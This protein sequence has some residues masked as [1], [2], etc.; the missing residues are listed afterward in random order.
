MQNK[1]KAKE[2][3][4]LLLD[5]DNKIVKDNRTIE[6]LNS[7]FASVFTKGKSSPTFQNSPWGGRGGVQVKNRE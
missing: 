6:L 5:D 2:K 3:F 4:D 7:H 1:R